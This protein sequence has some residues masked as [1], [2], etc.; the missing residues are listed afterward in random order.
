[1]NALDVACATSLA[2][3]G[4]TCTTRFSKRAVSPHTARLR[5]AR[6]P[7]TCPRCGAAE[8]KPCLTPAGKA[9]TRLHAARND[10]A[11]QASRKRR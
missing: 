3:P 5:L 2:V 11:W 10:A 4:E 6:A 7:V 9:Q 8:R 1:M